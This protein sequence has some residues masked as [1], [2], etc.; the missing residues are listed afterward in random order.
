MTLHQQQL[1]RQQLA[2]QQSLSNAPKH[3]VTVAVTALPAAAPLSHLPA[4]EIVNAEKK[5]KTRKVVHEA[6]AAIVTASLRARDALVASAV[7]TSASSPAVVSARG[8]DKEKKLKNRKLG[9]PIPKKDGDAD[10]SSAAR[11]RKPVGPPELPRYEPLFISSPPPNSQY[12]PA[13]PG[14][15]GPYATLTADDM[16]RVAEEIRKKLA[17]QA[18]TSPA[19]RTLPPGEGTDSSSSA[20]VACTASASAVVSSTE[21]SSADNRARTAAASMDSAR[22]SRAGSRSIRRPQAPSILARTKSI[23]LEAL[24]DRAP[25][26]LK[27]RA[28]DT[29]AAEAAG[30]GTGL[31]PINLTLTALAMSFADELEAPRPP[32]PRPERQCVVTIRSEL[33]MIV[34]VPVESTDRRS[35]GGKR[36]PHCS[37]ADLQ[38]TTSGERQS[39][40]I[41]QAGISQSETSLDSSA[42]VDSTRPM[43]PQAISG[44]SAEASSSVRYCRFPTATLILPS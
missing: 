43:Q 20:T 28:E 8:G 39:K 38:R 12:N 24:L 16:T 4:A 18:D 31:G 37:S 13:P 27:Q 21:V 9:R 35:S 44:E 36:K 15:S 5:R 22:T 41:S 33:D 40:S 10:A 19:V 30:T 1:I 17:D 6:T 11:S 7:S 25:P 32:I 26:D 42:S 23:V 2:Q 3:P 14:Y 34:P 29:L